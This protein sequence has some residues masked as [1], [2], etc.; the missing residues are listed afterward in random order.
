MNLSISVGARG[1]T[2]SQKQLWEVWDELRAYYPQITF[3]P[4]WVSTTGD[5]DL[6]TSL[7]FMENSNF[8]TKEIDERQLAGDFRLSIHSAKDVT[9]PLCKGLMTVCLTTGKDPADSLVVG[10]SFTGKGKIATSSLRREKAIL[11]QFPEAEIVDIRGTIEQRLHQVESGLVEGLVVAECALIRLGLTHQTR[12]KLSGPVARFQGQLAVIAREG[13]E[14][15]AE[16]FSCIDSRK[17]II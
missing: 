9:D 17:Q 12:I 3:T 7:R 13:D 6:A 1:S 14:E 4:V 5:K 2:L 15:M 8:F 16:L 11:E 10:E